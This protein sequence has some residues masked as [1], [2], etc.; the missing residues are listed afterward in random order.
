[1]TDLLTI[2]RLWMVRLVYYVARLVPMQE[3]AV[4]ATSHKDSIDGNLACIRAEMSSRTPPLPALVLAYRP[5]RGLLGLVRT[6]LNEAVAAY[7]LATSR[8]FI[9]DDYFFPIYVVRPRPGTTIVQTWHACGPFKKFGYSLAGKAFGAPEALLKRVRIHSNYD[10]CLVGSR[11]SAVCLAEAFRLPLERFVSELGI[12][13]TDLLVGEQQIAMTAEAVRRRYG[14]P[15]GC[16]VVLYAPTFR[17]E[18]VTTARSPDNLD[19]RLMLDVLGDDH[20]I[21][22]RLHPF[23]RSGGV[24]PELEGFVIDV[25]AHSEVNELMLVSDVL[26]TDYSSVIFDFALLGRPII[27]FAPDHEAYENERGFYFDFRS[28]GPGPVFES[29]AALAEYLKAGDF[30]LPRVERFRAHWFDVADGNATR[31]FVD[32]L[33]TPRLAARRAERGL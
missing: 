21:L 2:A 9:V 6:A 31:R 32:R 4:L 13:R 23:V 16:R 29:T 19:L 20:V 7:Y 5:R 10:I 25:S 26:I 18:D 27:L 15:V 1:M 11:P 24:A 8:L 33:V 17:G 28:E 30:D 22:L 14:I 3:R 12:P